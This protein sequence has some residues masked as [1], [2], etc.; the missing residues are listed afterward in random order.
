MVSFGNLPNRVSELTGILFR[1]AKVAGSVALMQGPRTSLRKLVCPLYLL[2]C[3]NPAFSSEN[4]DTPS[5]VYSELH[6]LP[7]AHP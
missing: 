2:T 3:V 5:P 1:G 4:A 6:T 7:L